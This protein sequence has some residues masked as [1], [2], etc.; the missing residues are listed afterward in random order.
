MANG[1]DELDQYDGTYQPQRPGNYRA[2]LESV[3]DGDYEW[4]I[5]SASLERTA[6]TKSRSDR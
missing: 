2:A 1:F 6:M 5:L 4:M 3:A